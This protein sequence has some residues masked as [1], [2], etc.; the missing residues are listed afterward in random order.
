MRAVGLFVVGAAAIYGYQTVM[1]L[2]SAP[3][4]DDVSVIYGAGGNVGVLRT[5]R[6]AVVVGLGKYG[7]L[8]VGA[9]T[10]A[11]RLVFLVR[12]KRGWRKNRKWNRD[13]TGSAIAGFA[14]QQIRSFLSDADEPEY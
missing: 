13:L 5:D 3:I 2:E 4:T 10:E 9:L 14:Q 12:P 6:G 7:E 11:V 1:G 8:T